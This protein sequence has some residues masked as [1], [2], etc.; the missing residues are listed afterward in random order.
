MLCIMQTCLN[1]NGQQK[2]DGWTLK[3]GHGAQAIKNGA[4]QQRKDF[5]K[6]MFR[7][8]SLSLSVFL[9]LFLS[10]YA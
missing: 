9:F 6:E 4:T 5:E 1:I 10:L 7:S 8:L 2:S 3:T